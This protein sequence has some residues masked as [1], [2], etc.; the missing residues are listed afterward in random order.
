MRF[1]DDSIVFYKKWLREKNEVMMKDIMNDYK[2]NKNIKV[3]DIEN[4]FNQVMKELEIKQKVMLLVE[5]YM[6]K[7]DEKTH[8]L[9]LD[10]MMG[11][12]DDSIVFYKK[13]LREKKEVMMKDIINDYK[14]NKNI[15]VVDIENL[16]DQVIKEL[17]NLGQ[18]APA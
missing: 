13:W 3:V 12:G 6:G 7:E 10:G 8:N 18:H 1:G 17:Y 11:F 2:D 14:D 5:K 15:K 9:L 16:V 4:L